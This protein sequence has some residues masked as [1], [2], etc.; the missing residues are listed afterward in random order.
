M[1]LFV[2]GFVATLSCLLNVSKTLL[3]VVTYVTL[4][5]KGCTCR[6]TQW[7]MHQFMSGVMLH[8]LYKSHCNRISIDFPRIRALI[9]TNIIIDKIV[10]IKKILS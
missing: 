1:L 9:K 3:T 7:Q 2:C 10:Y 6:S 4:D 5:M 8:H